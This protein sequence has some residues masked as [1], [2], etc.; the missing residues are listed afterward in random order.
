MWS[1]NSVIWQLQI[2]FLILHLHHWSYPPSPPKVGQVP[3]SIKTL[4]IQKFLTKVALNK[5]KSARFQVKIWLFAWKQTQLTRCF[6]QLVNFGKRTHGK[7][8]ETFADKSFLGGLTSPYGWVSRGSFQ[9]LQTHTFETV[10]K[11][12][13]HQSGMISRLHHLPSRNDPTL[14]SCSATG[15]FITPA[16]DDVTRPRSEW[17]I[18]SCKIGLLYQPDA[19][20]YQSKYRAGHLSGIIHQNTPI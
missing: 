2:T 7:A 9:D 11:I 14:N 6:S 10:S 16:V 20:H 19:V 13:P 18:N 5:K 4:R 1:V 3:A 12:L 15:A 8:S 17:S